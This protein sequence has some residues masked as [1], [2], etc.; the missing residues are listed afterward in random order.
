MPVR[1]GKDVTLYV[2]TDTPPEVIR[3]MNRLKAEGRF[4]E[5]IMDIVTS[6]VRRERPNEAFA[7]AE[8]DGPYK[9]HE[10]FGALEEH[11]TGSI[12]DSADSD[13]SAA[14]SRR[15]YSP[16]DLFRLAGRNAGK[17]LRN[18]N[19]NDEWSEREG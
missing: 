7:A 12:G 1:P 2:P 14:E 19:D 4:S 15:V 11:W 5:G 18:A 3:Y 16:D 10:S 8:A 17:L 6:H 9:E 13:E